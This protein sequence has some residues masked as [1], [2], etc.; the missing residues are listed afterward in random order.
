MTITAIH[1]YLIN[2]SKSA[3]LSPF[4]RGFAYGDGVFRTLPVEKARAHN[5]QLHYAKLV[6]DC[7]VLGIVCP[8]S[9]ILL[10]DIERLFAGNQTKAVAKIIVTR[11]E[12]D[13]GYSMPSL[14]Q[15]TRVVIK[16]AFP[17][18]PAEAFEYGVRLHLCQTKLGFQPRL[19]GIKHLNR[20]E[21]VLARAEWNDPAI[22][23][24][25]MLDMEGNV[26][27]C[28]MSNIFARY[29]R[30]LVTPDLNRC[31]VAG[32]TRQRILELAPAMEYRTEIRQI[33]L[34]ELMDADEIIICNSLFGAW[35]VRTL[36]GKSWE[37]QSLASQS[38]TLLQE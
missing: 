30:T 22:A 32:M 28:V 11:G 4:D 35:Q 13:R 21:N 38:I 19:A 33:A 14:A 17:S 26:V 6:H 8:A 24:G 31:G 37:A 5:W 15:P 25:L 16:S 2:G 27:E 1:E 23:D 18:Y 20:L 9:Q 12:G 3:S 7:N 36:A 34:D 29:G 10:N